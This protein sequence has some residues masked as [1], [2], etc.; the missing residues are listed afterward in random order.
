MAAVSVVQAGTEN[1][2][3]IRITLVCRQAKCKSYSVVEACT[4]ISGATEARQRACRFRVP[5]WSL[6]WTMCETVKLQLEKNK[7][8]QNKILDIP[9]I[10]AETLGTEWNS[11][12]NCLCAAGSRAAGARL[13]EP[14]GRRD[15]EAVAL[16]GAWNLAS[17][18]PISI[19]A[20][21]HLHRTKFRAVFMNTLIARAE[22]TGSIWIITGPWIWYGLLPQSLKLGAQPLPQ[23]Q[24]K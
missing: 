11:P 19:P 18:A 16:R 22:P 7:T 13:L 1:G 12:R 6:C 8:K 5:A 20:Y 21:S 4:K 14:I 2:H 3:V 10:L 17:P 15:R 9:Q 24:T 23:A